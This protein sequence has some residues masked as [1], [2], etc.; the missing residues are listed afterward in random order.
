[1]S[2]AIAYALPAFHL[3]IVHRSI[4]NFR[5]ICNHKLKKKSV[6]FV[7]KIHS[8]C[9]PKNS[10]KNKRNKKPQEEPDDTIFLIKGD[11]EKHRQVKLLSLHYFYCFKRIE[12][13][14]EGYA[15]LSFLIHCF[16]NP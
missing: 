1:M 12:E 15:P 7:Q 6:P 14:W 13:Q 9:I 10:L 5:P 2:H 4:S 16:M 3:K 11:A 8:P